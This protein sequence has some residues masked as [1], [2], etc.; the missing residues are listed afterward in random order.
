[1]ADLRREKG[2]EYAL[3]ALRLLC[4]RNQPVRILLIGDGERRQALESMC[5]DLDIDGRVTFLG[6]Q[7]DPRLYVSAMDA[8]L[9]PSYTGETFSMALLEALL[10][11]KPVI[12]TRVGGAHEI[13]EDGVNGY[14]VEPRDP[15]QIARCIERWI[16]SPEL[17]RE[18]SARAR[19]SIE[20]RYTLEAMIQ[21]T[22]MVLSEALLGSRHDP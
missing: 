4:D 22:D 20:A 19:M 21:K 18:M 17:L 7:T 15:G 10:L 8:V 2:H 6:C 5:R 16:E 13:V 9:L 3:K 11:G 12:A 14:L 1:V